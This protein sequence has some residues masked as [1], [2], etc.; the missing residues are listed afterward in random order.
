MALWASRLSRDSPVRSA[1]FFG[2]WISKLM[3]AALRTG[4]TTRLWD[5]ARRRVIQ[6]HGADLGKPVR[7]EPEHVRED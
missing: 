3:R 4:V 1:E 7:G 2:K 6:C 5:P